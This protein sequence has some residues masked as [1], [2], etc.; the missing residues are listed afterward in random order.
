M[1]SVLQNAGHSFAAIAGDLSFSTARGASQRTMVT[2]DL[3][4]LVSALTSPSSESRCEWARHLLLQASQSRNDA[5]LH[6]LYSSIE[7]ESWEVF[8][9]NLALAQRNGGAGGGGGGRRLGGLSDSDLIA[10]ELS[11][12]SAAFTR[13]AAAA[14][15]ARAAAMKDTLAADSVATWSPAVAQARHCMA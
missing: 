2:I 1:P 10:S 9:Q 11:E 3:L 4:G 8:Q 14:A 12:L 5:P 13:A 6:A 7:R 15:A